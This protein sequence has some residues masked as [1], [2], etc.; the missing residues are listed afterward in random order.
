[1]IRPT[2]TMPTTLH[3]LAHTSCGLFIL[4]CLVHG[5]CN[6]VSR[7]QALIREEGPYSQCVRG[8]SLDRLLVICDNFQSPTSYV[9]SLFVFAART[10]FLPACHIQLFYSAQFSKLVIFLKSLVMLLGTLVMLLGTLVMLLGTLGAFGVTRDSSHIARDSSHVTRD[11]SHVAR[12]SSH[13]ARDSGHVARDSS[14]RLQN[15][16][17][18]SR[19]YSG[20][21][22]FELKRELSHWEIIYV[23]LRS[24]QSIGLTRF[25]LLSNNVL[26]AERARTVVRALA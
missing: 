8:L 20:S 18:I 10:V 17:Y 16:V 21:L 11:S 3:Y 1:M 23:L 9:I 7:S 4:L 5:S 2:H 12:D 26:H 6:S 22:L 13:V 15:A 24:C 25:S 19:V 14:K